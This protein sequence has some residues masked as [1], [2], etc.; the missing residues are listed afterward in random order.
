MLPSQDYARSR[1]REIQFFSFNPVDKR[2]A[3]T[4][5]DDHGN[6]HRTSKG[7]C[8][9]G[10]VPKFLVALRYL[11]VSNIKRN[12]LTGPLPVEL[13]EKSNKES[14]SF[15]FHYATSFRIQSH[16]YELQGLQLLALAGML[17]E[18]HH[19]SANESELSDVGMSLLGFGVVESGLL[20][21]NLLASLLRTQKCWESSRLSS[22]NVAS[23]GECSS[24]FPVREKEQQK[25]RSLMAEVLSNEVETQSDFGQ[26]KRKETRF[27]NFWVKRVRMSSGSCV[28]QNGGTQSFT[29]S[30]TQTEGVSSMYVNIG[31]CQWS[32]NHCG[33]RF[34]YG[35]RLKGYAN[36]RHP[37][38]HKRCGRGK[39]VLR[40]QR[41]PPDY[42]KQL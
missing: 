9:T 33:A 15:K 1:T 40:Q 39:V 30:N 16:I 5:I 19:H 32:C 14:L 13:L 6:W 29:T 11:K 21:G 25:I 17:A 41:D 37:K 38:Y 36:A 42:I 26:R 2:T 27:N 12:L 18:F 34:W 23:Q 20:S 24:R 3:L 10:K 4:Y 8:L 35:K 28:Q 7:S 31:D 22:G